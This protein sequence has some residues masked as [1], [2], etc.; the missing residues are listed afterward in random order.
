MSVV[1]Q[2]HT[3][4]DRGVEGVKVCI[5]C[6]CTNTQTDRQTHTH[7]HTHTHTQTDRQTDTHTHIHTHT[8]THTQ[9]RPFTPIA[10]LFL[11]L[12]GPASGTNKT[13]PAATFDAQPCTIPVS[14]LRTAVPR[15][16]ALC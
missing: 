8:Y 3:H 6:C 5:E 10:S 14:S 9:A 7:T 13:V 1:A 2:T 4:T 16:R 11:L 15:W 12:T